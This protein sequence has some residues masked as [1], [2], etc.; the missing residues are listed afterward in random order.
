MPPEITNSAFGRLERKM[1]Q[2]TD[3]VSKLILIEERQMTQA[4]RI[5]DVEARQEE[6]DKAQRATDAKVERW[7]NRGVGMWAV[8]VVLFAGVGL[9]VKFFK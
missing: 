3:A 4:H 9:A 6:A 5:S 2:L 1:D 7:I 8:V